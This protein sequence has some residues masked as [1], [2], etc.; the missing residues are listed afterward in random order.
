M[1]VVFIGFRHSHAVDLYKSAQA[2]IEIDITGVWD[3]SPEGRLFAENYGIQVVSS[4]YSEALSGDAD[5]AV[6]GGCYADRGKTAI[7]ALKSGKHVYS[8]KPLCTSLDELDEIERLSLISGLKVGCMFTLRYDG[9]M[10]ALR[11]YILRGEL[12]SV[13][14]MCFTAQHPLLYGTRP[15]WY[16]KNK[17]YGGIINDISVH[18]VDIITYLTGLHFKDVTAARTWNHFS[19]NDRDFRDCGH[20]MYKVENGA[21]VLADV[22]YAAPGIN[23]YKLPYYWRITVWGTKGVAEISLCDGF[24]KITSSDG[25]T[26]ILRGDPELTGCLTD[27]INEIKGQKTILS[28][29]EVIEASRNALTLQKAADLYD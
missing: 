1:K 6:L 17:K 19:I 4:D 5:I 28:T 25:K 29:P 23:G 14:S 22:S 10:A 26:E 7:A 15:D 24:S 9:G 20:I 3:D 11:N 21:G 2:N 27:F 18:G 16:F 13:G 8:D 12:G